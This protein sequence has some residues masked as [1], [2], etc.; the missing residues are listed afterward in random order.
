MS[1]CIDGVE[2]ALGRDDDD[3]RIMGF[4][5]YV[6]SRSKP[7]NQAHSFVNPADCGNAKATTAAIILAAIQC[8]EHLARKYGDPVCPEAVGRNAA[9][10][11][12]Q[13]VRLMAE[14][15]GGLQAKLKLLKGKTAFMDNQAQEVY[16]RVVWAVSQGLPVSV[17]EMVSID[18]IIGVVMSPDK[19]G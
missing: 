6:H 12:G 11:L 15:S 3:P 2:V 10:A 17:N 18:N 5:V 7:Q 19:G 14:L 13:E 9:D 16:Q 1:V 4:N 8:A